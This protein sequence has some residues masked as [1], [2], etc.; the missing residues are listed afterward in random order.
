MLPGSYV[1]E[2]RA[3]VAVTPE[4]A[5]NAV[6]GLGGDERFYAPREL[7]RVRGR[8]ERLSGGTGHRIAGPDRPLEVGDAMD[9]W[10]VVEVQ[11]PTRLRVRALSRLPGTAYLEI[12]VYPRGSGTELR[13]RSEFEPTGALGHA[14][15]WSELPAH[16]LVFA[17]M[18]RRLAGIVATG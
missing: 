1:D 17:L 8:L 9:F 7:W 15:W 3:V 13:V 14:F 10:E 12:G 11:P 6:L 2:H 4:R 16:K 5:W 18:T